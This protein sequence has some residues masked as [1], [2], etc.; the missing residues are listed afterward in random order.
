[1]AKLG[2]AGKVES[3]GGWEER[4]KKVGVVS[5]LKLFPCGSLGY[6]QLAVTVTMMGQSGFRSCNQSPLDGGQSPIMCYQ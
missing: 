1:M 2:K 6:A 4:I 5:I 3:R